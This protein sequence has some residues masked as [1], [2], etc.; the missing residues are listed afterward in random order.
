MSGEALAPGDSAESLPGEEPLEVTAVRE[1]KKTDE[2]QTEVPNAVSGHDHESDD[3]VSHVLG[4][5]L[6]DVSS[7]S[8]PL[9]DRHHTTSTVPSPTQPIDA[10]TVIRADATEP[11]SARDE[12]ARDETND[13][14]ANA[15]QINAV[16]DEVLLSLKKRRAKCD[17][18]LET[19]FDDWT[20][21]TVLD[22][23]CESAEGDEFVVDLV[24]GEVLRGVVLEAVALELQLTQNREALELLESTTAVDDALAQCVSF[25]ETHAIKQIQNLAARKIQ[26]AHRG[27]VGRKI[28]NGLKQA[29]ADA[30]TELGD[31]IETEEG[32]VTHG[33][34]P[35][36]LSHEQ[37]P[38]NKSVRRRLTQMGYEFS[39]KRE[40]GLAH[41]LR[42]T[43]FRKI[44]LALAFD[45]H[46][47][48]RGSVLDGPEDGV[49]LKSGDESASQS[50]ADFD[51]DRAQRSG[52]DR[53]SLS[54]DKHETELDDSGDDEPVNARSF[55]STFVPPSSSN[56]RTPVKP[57]TYGFPNLLEDEFGVDYG[58]DEGMTDLCLIRGIANGGGTTAEKQPSPTHGASHDDRQNPSSFGA[59][60]RKAKANELRWVA[61]KRAR[62][63]KAL[64]DERRRFEILKEELE[65]IEKRRAEQKR[66]RED[67]KQADLELRVARE[68][69]NK[70]A[71]AVLVERTAW[72]NKCRSDALRRVKNGGTG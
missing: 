14:N 70:L 54:E 42:T 7:D 23:V 36:P 31:E 35:K 33:L 17:A 28:V 61:E 26:A 63:K 60:Q 9:S 40:Y 15:T 47:E 2:S 71:R 66:Q 68:E 46:N 25:V 8:V 48:H 32:N 13:A 3:V 58:S 72:E 27:N 18:D 39:E 16:L 41:A 49:S 19:V 51:E 43:L 56:N 12:K 22:L 50:E 55:D 44:D 10:T 20:I 45:L 29:R 67:K 53:V 37:P 6:D 65:G 30:E 59:V 62:E 1:M 34:K 5:L 4:D 21:D 69:N 11:D 24:L 57:P 64:E 52:D 38:L